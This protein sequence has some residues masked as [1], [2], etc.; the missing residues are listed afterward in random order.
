[1]SV[2]ALVA[3]AHGSRDPR[4]AATITALAAEVRGQAPDLDVRVSFLDL[5]APRLGDVLDGVAADG[6]RHAVVVPLLLGNAFHARSDVPGLVASAASRNPLLHIDTSDVLGPDPGT[7]AAALS[8]LRD[9]LAAGPHLAGHPVTSQARHVLRGTGFPCEDGARPRGGSHVADGSPTSQVLH[10]LRG[11]D[12]PGEDPLCDPGLGVVLASVGSSRADANRVVADRVDGWRE[13]FGWAAA[14][15]AYVTAAEPTPAQAIEA[16]RAAGARRV[17][18]VPWVLAP[19][20]LPDRIVEAAADGGALVADPVGPH[21]DLA[22]AVLRQWA[23]A[24]EHG[25]AARRVG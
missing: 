24:V 5:S 19:G 12:M 23:A 2:P 13:R 6:H 7:D 11:P 3:V 10:G 22:A 20:R 4:S 15:A 1:M 9:A 25:S 14:S 16:V 18:V 8:R 21:P 17:V